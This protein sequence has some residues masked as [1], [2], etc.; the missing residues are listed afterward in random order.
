M[1]EKPTKIVSCYGHT[2]HLHAEGIFAQVLQSAVFCDKST[3]FSHMA[4]PV[5]SSTSHVFSLNPDASVWL[6]DRVLLEFVC[7]VPAVRP[8]PGRSVLTVLR[9]GFYPACGDSAP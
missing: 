6:R 5:T 1:S 7:A 4:C 2:V 9:P 3:R 8:L